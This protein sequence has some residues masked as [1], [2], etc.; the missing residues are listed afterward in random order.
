[1]VDNGLSLEHDKCFFTG[2]TGT[3]YGGNKVD[4]YSRKA[5]AINA[6]HAIFID[7]T[8]NEW[9]EQRTFSQITE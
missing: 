9:S 1:M 5:D 7:K 8:G 4:E 6:F 2:R 3:I